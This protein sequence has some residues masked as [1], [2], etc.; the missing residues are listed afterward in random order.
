MAEA[1]YRQRAAEFNQKMGLSDPDDYWEDA[2]VRF[3]VIAEE[4]G[5]LMEA[6]NKGRED[7]IPEELA[8]VVIT[9]YTGADTLDLEL[10]EEIQP[11]VAKNRYD[12]TLREHAS[13]I[14][15]KSAGVKTALDLRNRDTV[16]ASLVELLA[17]CHAMAREYDIDLDAEFE[18]KM[19]YNMKKSGEKVNGKPVDDVT[20]GD[21]Q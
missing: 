7:D 2:F 11:P 1:N 21:T 9:I 3:S 15:R 12:D 6:V 17:Q 14:F 19:D 13:R 4:A 5:E 20:E 18:R 8:D 16:R 10:P